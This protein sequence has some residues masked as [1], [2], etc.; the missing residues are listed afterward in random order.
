MWCPAD[1]HKRAGWYSSMQEMTPRPS[2]VREQKVTESQVTD[3]RPKKNHSQTLSVNRGCLLPGK[4][5]GAGRTESRSDVVWFA[6]RPVDS[7]KQARCASRTQKMPAHPLL[8]REQ[9]VTELQVTDARPKKNYGQ[10]VSAI[11]G[12]LLPSKSGGAG[13]VSGTRCPEKNDSQTSSG[14][15]GGLLTC[16]SG[17]AWILGRRKCLLARGFSVSKR[18]RNHK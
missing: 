1:P 17:R 2:L 8:V 3:A 15:L 11:C 7:H 9:K 18:L 12:G 4:S 16:K 14:L 6:W 13:R 5:D 10:N